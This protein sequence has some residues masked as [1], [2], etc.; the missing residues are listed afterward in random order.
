MFTI[1]TLA[2]AAKLLVSVIVGKK[3]GDFVQRGIICLFE[4]ERHARV[5]YNFY[6]VYIGCFHERNARVSPITT[7]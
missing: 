7:S 4:R 5:D 3:S 1:G 6:V 2:V